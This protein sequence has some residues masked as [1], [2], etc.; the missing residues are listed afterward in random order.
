MKCPCGPKPYEN[1]CGPYH[2]GKA[3]PPSPEA[4]MRSRYSAFA[5]NNMSY[6][7][8]TMQGPAL[9]KWKEPSDPTPVEWISLEVLS[10]EIDKHDSTLGR[11]EF[12]A[13]YRVNNQDQHLHELS[14]FKKIDERWFYT[15]GKHIP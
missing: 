9:A 13:H 10:S 15:D 6:L 2:E 3:L 12:I 1:C 4:L 8:E 11:V 5:K 7:R 14:E